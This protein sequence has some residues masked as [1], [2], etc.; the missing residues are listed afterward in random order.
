MITKILIADD[1]QIVR[2]G[3]ISLIN[4]QQNMEI[5]GEAE[6]GRN[7]VKLVKELKPD[8]VVMDISMPDLNGIEATKQILAENPDVK[9]IGLSIHSDRRFITR[10]LTAGAKGYLLKDCAFDELALAINSVQ[11]DKFY[12]SPQITGVVVENILQSETSQESPKLLLLSS[13]EREVLQMLAE[14]KSTKQI[15]NDLH[16]S[17]K[18]IETHRQNVMNKLEIRNIATLIK[19]AIREG[20]TSL[21]I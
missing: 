11:Q 15:A 8:V 17:V 18:T 1:H 13:R 10:M 3:L 20:L 21:D 16:L 6:D 4:K 2:E 9:I 14:G 12:L 5:I 19:F 7:A